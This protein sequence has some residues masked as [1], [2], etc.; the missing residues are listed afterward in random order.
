MNFASLIIPRR[1]SALKHSSTLFVG[2]DV[3][4][5][6]IAVVYVAA[7]REAEVISLGGVAEMTNQ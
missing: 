2:L 4:E 6:T 5:E 3:H 7:E 1:R